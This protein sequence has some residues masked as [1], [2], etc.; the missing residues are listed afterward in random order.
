MWFLVHYIKKHGKLLT[1]NI[2]YEKMDLQQRCF[3]IYKEI[4]KNDYSKCNVI[5]A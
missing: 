4:N 3:L 5:D 1:K 2:K